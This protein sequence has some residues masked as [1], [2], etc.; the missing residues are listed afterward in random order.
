MNALNS[1]SLFLMLALLSGNGSLYA[2]EEGSNDNKALAEVVQ[3]F[4]KAT[5][6][7]AAAQFSLGTAYDS[8]H[9]VQA[10]PLKAAL[11]Y[12]KAAKQNHVDAQFNLAVLY[13]EGTG[14]R[15]DF[16]QAVYWYEQAASQEMAEA[17]NNLGLMYAHGHGV[18][19]DYEK[20]YG[21]FK[22]AAD[23]KF[24]DALYNLGLLHQEGMGT[25][26]DLLQAF[27]L[28]AQ[29]RADNGSAAKAYE[30]LAE[31]LTPQEQTTALTGLK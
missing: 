11:W 16:R 15:Q 13:D 12:E 10:D 4:E 19:R 29:A 17:S 24:S 3:L 14:V 6:G 31:H 5:A 27:A 22:K 7:D 23:M 30:R 21:Y 25:N 2:S 9:G 8:G 28:F 1:Y 18:E 20:A 26:K